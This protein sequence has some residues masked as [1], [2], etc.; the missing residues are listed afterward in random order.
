MVPL[1]R[2]RRAAWRYAVAAL[3]CAL[4]ARPAAAQPSP[5][6]P[7][8]DV[9]Y[10]YIDALQA[11]GELRA[12]S[13]LERPYTVAAVRAA[14]GESDGS[15]RGS[16]R[17][18]D[19]WRRALLA[20][21]AKYFPAD[22]GGDSASFGASV[23]PY[24]TAQSSGQREL[25]RADSANDVGPGFTARAFLHTGPLT[26]AARGYGDRRLRD[27]PDFTG[28]RDRVLGG[29]VEDAYLAAH[30]R[31]V[32]VAAGRVGR[33][34][35]PPGVPGLQVGAA[36]YSYDHLF[37]RLGGSRVRLSTVVARLDDFY[38]DPDSTIAQR[39]FTAHR[40]AG[41][42]G[43]VE[44]ALGEAVVYGGPGRGFEPSLANPVGVYQVTQYA[45]Q[46][47][48]NVNFTADVAWRP[49]W[50]G[51]YA[52]QLLLDDFQI[53]DC[54]VGCEEPTSYGATLA[55][56]GVPVV[57]PVRGFA[58][59]VR[60]SFLSYRTQNAWEEYSSLGVGLG[61]RF[62][63][64]DEVRA[65]L[66]LGPILP[67]PLRAYAALRRQGT[68]SFRDPYPEP[69]DFPTVAGF[70]GGVVTRTARVGLS[71]AGRLPGGL[72]LRGDVGI[73]SVRNANRQPGASR[74][75][76][77]G[78]VTVAYEPVWLRAVGAVR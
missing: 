55:A 75:G 59:Y 19:R 14:V 46:E 7:L 18:L 6:L 72:E 12:L 1:T 20:A 17:G 16:D 38:Y 3:V 60:S 64:F 13:I 74:T 69:D 78:R 36:P 77:E 33:Q 41:R 71:G 61:T 25:T 23:A 65:G 52:V 67:V 9:A 48:A 24:V 34:W 57:G 21:T 5:Y 35:A 8:D 76:F 39:Y 42:V 15:A 11:R 43:S 54:G 44:L 40:L 26:A 37:L 47:Q 32:E 73:N 28:R 49:R 45:E 66:D 30:W 27:D 50:G 10:G 68:G 51:S 70:L 31:F 4:A 62:V 63:D 56:D 53:D 2:R 29:R 22:G 58:S